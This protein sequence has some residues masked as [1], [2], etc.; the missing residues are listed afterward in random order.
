MQEVDSELAASSKING[1]W[2]LRIRE[3][4]QAKVIIIFHLYLGTRKQCL[5]SPPHILLPHFFC[6]FERK[7]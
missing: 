7:R 2:W 1:S 5:R 4:S 6:L 3:N